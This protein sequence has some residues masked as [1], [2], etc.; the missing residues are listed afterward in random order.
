MS[1]PAADN[2][3]ETV[4]QIADGPRQCTKP[5]QKGRLAAC[6]LRLAG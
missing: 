4:Q 5:D 3:K 6:A 1:S 2:V